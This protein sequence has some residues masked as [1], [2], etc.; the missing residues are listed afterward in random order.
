MRHLLKELRRKLVTL[1]HA[2]PDPAGQRPG[3]VTIEVVGSPQIEMR[4]QVRTQLPAQGHVDR[5]ENPLGI[6]VCGNVAF[7]E[8]RRFT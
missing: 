1:H 2:L 7:K 3:Q 4:A 8:P 5:H 6:N